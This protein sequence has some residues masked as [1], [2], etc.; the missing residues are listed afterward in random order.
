MQ[1]KIFSGPVWLLT[2][3]ELVGLSAHIV[4][5]KVVLGPPLELV[6]S[7][8]WL[9]LMIGILIAIG[10]LLYKW[11][12]WN[13]L[14]TEEQEEWEG[15]RESIM[16]GMTWLFVLVSW[17]YFVA[18]PAA[19]L[20]LTLTTV[21]AIFSLVQMCY[22]TVTGQIIW[23][24][25]LMTLGVSLCYAFLVKLGFLQLHA[26]AAAI[27]LA[28]IIV[29]LLWELLFMELRAD[30]IFDFLKVLGGVLPPVLFLLWEQP[31][32]ADNIYLLVLAAVVIA[33]FEIIVIL[34][35]RPRLGFEIP[36]Q[37]ENE[38]CCP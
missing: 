18:H 35:F 9:G 30:D 19:L 5:S 7:E 11:Q 10:L 8:L 25:L 12:P 32:L 31:Q 38:V 13:A 2:V 34:G 26:A 20:L 29:W 28:G 4:F 22:N 14:S 15:F 24:F 16:Y 6:Q 1:W 23:L 37:Q 27:P 36:G 17:A 33:L 3:L 21:L